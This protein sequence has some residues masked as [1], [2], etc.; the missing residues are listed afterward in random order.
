MGLVVGL[1]L[2]QNLFAA[3]F[4]YSF[5]SGQD[6]FDALSQSN[7]VARG[8]LL[9]IADLG[10]NIK[11]SECFRVPMRADA[12]ESLISAYLEFWPNNVDFAKQAPDAVL[13]MMVE[14]FPC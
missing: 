4:S 10:K 6:L 11:G 13:D 9:G 1:I 12:D 7:D 14:H 8:Y 3:D 2:S 5:M